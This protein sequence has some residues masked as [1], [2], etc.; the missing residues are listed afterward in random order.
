MMIFI[1]I[2]NSNKGLTLTELIVSSVL[3]GII[4]LSIAS[5]IIST[6]NMQSSTSKKNIIIG[7]V[8]AAMIE[9]RKDNSYIKTTN[10]VVR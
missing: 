5:I 10:L 4:M 8:T 7:R 6:Q 2:K 3:I 9:I 1:R